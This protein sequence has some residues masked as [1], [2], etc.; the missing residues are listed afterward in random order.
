MDTGMGRRVFVGSVVAGLPLLA[1]S[2]GRA[3]GQAAGGTAHVHDGAV[4][5]P[6]L[7]HIARQLAAIHNAMRRDPRGEHL[8]AFAAQLQTLS[9][10][11]RQIDIDARLASAVRTLI[12]RDGRDALLYPKPDRDHLLAELRRYGAQPDARIVGAE[13]DLDY[14]RRSAALDALIANGVSA[15]L[16]SMAT[17]LEHAAPEF[18]RAGGN[19]VRVS[20]YDPA[21]WQGYCGEL[22]EQY[23]ENQFL[24]ATI[25]ASAAL[26]VVGVLFVPECIAWQLAATLLASV[27][28]ARCWNV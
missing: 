8:R 23:R 3:F 20:Q 5:D 19:V 26:P 1:T 10:Y 28:A 22:W 27:Y 4:A 15:R 9:V 11:G 13:S 7:E 2:A 6:V 12:D 21:Y 24:A 25:C 17:L 18:D 16:Q 14:A